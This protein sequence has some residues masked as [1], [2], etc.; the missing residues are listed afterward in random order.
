MT[1]DKD[2]GRTVTKIDRREMRR[3]A[4]AQRFAGVKLTGIEKL[5]GKL[6]GEEAAI[7]C[8]GTTLK[9]LHLEVIPDHL[10]RVAVNE[11][12]AKRD[13]KPDYWVLSD[14]PI[15]SEYA[16]VCPRET[17]I[18]AMHEATRSIKAFAPREVFTTMSQTQ[19]KTWDD[20]VN[21]FSRG[22]VLI[23]AVEML[24]YM[25]VRRFY[26]FGMDLF[27]TK[28]AY[29]FDGRRPPLASE[30]QTYD[31]ERCQGEG[32]G[33]TCDMWTTSR[34]KR[35]Q[36]KLEAIK[37]A[38]HWDDL[39]MFVV[40]SPHS[41]QN[42]IP[43]I[44]IEEFVDKVTV[45]APV[46]AEVT[47]ARGGKVAKPKAKKPQAPPREPG[48][49]PGGLPAAAGAP[50]V[51]VGWSEALTAFDAFCAELGDIPPSIQSLLNRIEAGEKSQDILDEIDRVNEL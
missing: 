8:S 49:A 26:I 11:G 37:K 48:A 47:G 32:L 7:F 5:K 40:N 27:R 42:L 39:E 30:C 20:G 12:I 45:P 43:K 13:L 31:T 21:F 22:T 41:Q 17:V 46:V 10:V 29:Y 16:K 44:T 28:K 23:G 1:I 9:D 3:Q 15:V 14:T 51:L 25:G 36:E 4:Q 18:L 2:A 6:D 19:I 33:R 35:M 50:A 38:G 24:R 34:L